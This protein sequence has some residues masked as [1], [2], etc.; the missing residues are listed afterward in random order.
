MSRDRTERRKKQ[1]AS[2]K[3]VKRSDL[4]LP[5]LAPASVPLREALAALMAPENRGSSSAR[6]SWVDA[7]ETTDDVDPSDPS[8]R[9]QVSHF[10]SLE[11]DGWM[12][13][14]AC[15]VVLLAWER[16]WNFVGHFADMRD[17]V[18]KSLLVEPCELA[19]TWLAILK[20]APNQLVFSSLPGWTGP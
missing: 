18:D 12:M 19:E 15:G 1:R 3:V 16:P 7:L 5:S 8:L 9:P 10:M 17:Q 2:L 4:N 13:P 11:A 14:L 6:P 20:L